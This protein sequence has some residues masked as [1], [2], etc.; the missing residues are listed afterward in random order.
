MT[1]YRI[2]EDFSTLE[3]TE[4]TSYYMDCKLCGLV[5]DHLFPPLRL[6]SDFEGE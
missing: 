6:S 5:L 3:I 1:G 4:I 2:I